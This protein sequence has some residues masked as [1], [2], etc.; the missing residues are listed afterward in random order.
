MWKYYIS[1]FNIMFS[2]VSIVQKVAN[3]NPERLV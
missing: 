2:V 3:F 1:V